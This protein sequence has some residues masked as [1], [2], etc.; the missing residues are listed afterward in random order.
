ML[1]RVEITV[2][3]PMVCM[4]CGTRFEGTDDLCLCL[5]NMIA[6]SLT[7]TAAALINRESELQERLELDR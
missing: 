4:Y 2:R 5:T 3:E 7:P 6:E 1:T